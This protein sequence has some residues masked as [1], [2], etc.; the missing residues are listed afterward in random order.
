MSGDGGVSC[1]HW[2]DGAGVYV[3]ESAGVDG[4]GASEKDVNVDGNGRA[5]GHVRVR[6]RVRERECESESECEYVS[7]SVSGDEEGVVA[8]GARD[9]GEDDGDGGEGTLSGDDEKTSGEDTPLK[10]TP[11]HSFGR[12]FVP[13]LETEEASV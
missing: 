6:V 10:T 3:N 12:V 1:F 4:S 5:Y 9:V 2:G 13:V 8:D 7:V 11:E